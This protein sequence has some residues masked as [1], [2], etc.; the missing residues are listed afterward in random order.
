MSFFTR[1]CKY[2]RQLESFFRSHEL[3][4]IYLHQIWIDWKVIVDI[5]KQKISVLIDLNISMHSL[6][7]ITKL[8]LAQFARTYNI[9]LPFLLNV[10]SEMVSLALLNIFRFWHWIWQTFLSLLPQETLLRFN[11]IY[12]YQ[13]YSKAKWKIFLNI[14]ALSI[15]LISFYLTISI[16]ANR[17]VS[18]HSISSNVKV[19][20]ILKFLVVGINLKDEHMEIFS[21]LRLTKF[22][23]IILKE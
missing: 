13:T 6:P 20:R 14:I 3:L 15:F 8:T 7:N 16:D 17:L 12:N 9:F 1:I 21:Y 18:W 4:S 10:L 11:E 5:W 19:Y 23:V 22:I 2:P